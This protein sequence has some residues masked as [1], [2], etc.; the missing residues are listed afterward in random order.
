MRGQQLGSTTGRRTTHQAWLCRRKWTANACSSNIPNIPNIIPNIPQYPTTQRRMKPVTSQ[1]AP[2]KTPLPRGFSAKAGP[3]QLRVWFFDIQNPGC[4]KSRSSMSSIFVTASLPG[5]VSSWDHQS[6]WAQS[7]KGKHRSL[8]WECYIL[9]YLMLPFSNK[10]KKHELP[11]PRVLDLLK[12]SSNSFVT[13]ELV[14][15]AHL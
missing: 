9:D 4:D 2:A 3:Q 8:F 10:R 1:N 11:L 5:E 13:G 14:V 6:L 7:R 12:V 15:S